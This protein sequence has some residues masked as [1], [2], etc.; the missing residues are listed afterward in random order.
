MMSFVLVF[1]LALGIGWGSRVDFCRKGRYHFSFRALVPSLAAARSAA[2]S[3]RLVEPSY[4]MTA[5]RAHTAQ[6]SSGAR[7]ATCGYTR[8][9][10]HGAAF[11]PRALDDG[12]AVRQL[13]EGPPGSPRSCCHITRR[14]AL[15]SFMGMSCMATKTHRCSIIRP[16]HMG[17]SGAFRE[18]PEVSHTLKNTTHGDRSIHLP[19]ARRAPGPSCLVLS[20][21]ICT[22]LSPEAPEGPRRPQKIRFDSEALFSNIAHLLG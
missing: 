20:Y 17:P 13:C 8:P 18:P 22:R 16:L 15:K 12:W 6:L 4:D 21:V 1:R 19:V 14:A 5:A 7:A 10:P 2:L 9:W 11:A 3:V